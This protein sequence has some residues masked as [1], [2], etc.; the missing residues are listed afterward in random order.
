MKALK[1]YIDFVQVSSRIKWAKWPS[2]AFYLAKERFSLGIKIEN[3]QKEITKT[4][5][6]AMTAP[7][8]KKAKE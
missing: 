7:I 6:K 4:K 1:P 2:H 5:P 8:K 3:A